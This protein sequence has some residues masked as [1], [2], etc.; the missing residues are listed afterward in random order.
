MRCV[1]VGCGAV[2]GTVAAGLVRDGHE[3]L[4]C[5]ADPR[6]VAEV[7]AHGLRICGPVESFTAALPVVA[8]AGLPARL[9][10]P[11]LV[12][13][14]AQHLAAVAALLAG[15][16]QGDGFVVCLS[17][18]LNA[19]VLADAVGRARVVEAVVNFGTDVLEP[20]VVLRG[21]RGTFVVGE[22]DGSLTG[23]V[24]ALAAGLAD[25]TATPDILGYLWAKQA[26]GAMLAATA[27]SDLPI[28]G[29]LA[30]PAWRPLLTGLA[31]E[32]L[33]Q[34]PAPAVPLDG[35]D[36]ADLAGSL[37][38]G[39]CRRDPAGGENGGA[40]V[41]ASECAGGFV[42]PRPVDAGC[43]SRGTPWLAASEAMCGSA[44]LTWC[45]A[46]WAG[47]SVRSTF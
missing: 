35:L 20:G 30:E 22:L 33:A 26:Y 6:V 21:N 11:V 10:C 37:G 1:V 45:A 28:A 16:V 15:R 4:A 14:K 43:F 9:D 23:R 13:V 39:R 24:R 47:T 17:N 27:V 42:R 7:N 12:A 41:A 40:R 18:G 3:V 25:A 29:V 31:G 2:G 32:V 5:D 46:R 34:A 44:R 8:P 38:G 19:G 36:P